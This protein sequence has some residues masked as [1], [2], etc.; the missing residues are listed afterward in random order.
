MSDKPERPRIVRTPEQKARDRQVREALQRKP[1]VAELLADPDTEGPFPSGYVAWLIRLA[2]RLRSLREAAG[3]GLDDLAE[4]ANVEVA[5]L[6][7]LEDGHL[8]SPPLYLL[9]AYARAL[10]LPLDR[11]LAPYGAASEEPEPAAGT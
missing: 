11:L 8:P 1:S 5:V 6:T 10:G 2:P 4:Q 9:W 3:L 7:D